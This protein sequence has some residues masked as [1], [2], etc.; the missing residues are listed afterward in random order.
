M[1]SNND[2]KLKEKYSVHFLA[3]QWLLVFSSYSVFM[4]AL[5]LFLESKVS[6]RKKKVFHQV[7]IT[8]P[9]HVFCKQRKETHTKYVKCRG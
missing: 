3:M 7:N 9:K 2:G 8:P 1:M 6:R 5:K 4:I